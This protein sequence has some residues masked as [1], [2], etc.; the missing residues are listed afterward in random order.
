MQ[1]E[2]NDEHLDLAFAKSLAETIENLT[3]SVKCL[4]NIKD[5]KPYILEDIK[6]NTKD[7]K[8]LK[9]VYKFYT[10]EKYE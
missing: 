4:K 9:R 1:I 7:L 10:G 3:T 5:P 6:E 8:A 2:I